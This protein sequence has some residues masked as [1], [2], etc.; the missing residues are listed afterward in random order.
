MR[1]HAQGRNLDTKTVELMP[2]PSGGTLF[3]GF[4]KEAESSDE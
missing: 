2:E 3:D 4:R 1:N